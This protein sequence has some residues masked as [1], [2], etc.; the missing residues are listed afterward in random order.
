MSL[1][2]VVLS[3][4]LEPQQFEFDWRHVPPPAQPSIDGAVT[5][6]ANLKPEQ[7]RNVC[8]G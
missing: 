4:Q 3:A 6:A 2:G 5:V 7:S 1:G 8:S